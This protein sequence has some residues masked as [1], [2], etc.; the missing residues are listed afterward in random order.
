MSWWECGPTPPQ[1]PH[2]S[3]PPGLAGCSASTPTWRGARQCASTCGGVA[4]RHLD[5]APRQAKPPV[6]AALPAVQ[7][8]APGLPTRLTHLTLPWPD[9][10]PDRQLTR[11][12]SCVPISGAAPCS[13]ASRS[14]HPSAH[15]PSC[16]PC[17][18]AGAQRGI[19]W[20]G[21]AHRGRPLGT[22]Y[23]PVQ[24]GCTVHPSHKHATQAHGVV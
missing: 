18:Q 9:T 17:S 14:P 24:E 12:G 8:K 4:C 6:L 7:L 21:W 16:C 22:T 15:P 2:S 11:L 20:V 10:R 13:S 19:R 5:A 23:G 3:R 1:A